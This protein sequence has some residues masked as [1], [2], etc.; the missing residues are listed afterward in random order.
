MS[1]RAKA[2]LLMVLSA[3]S[4]AAMQIVIAKSAA[5][6]P[7]F[8]QLFFRNLFAAGGA[9]ISVRRQG[10]RLM[11][12]PENRKLLVLRSAMGYLGMICL[13]YASAHAAQGDVAVMNKMSPFIVTLLAVVFLREKVARYQVAALALAF[14]GAAVVSNPTF[15][16]ELF[17]IFVA[18]LSAL[19]SGMAYTAVGALKGREAPGVVVFFFSA[20]ST[21]LSMVIMIPDFV[22]PTL[23]Q[24][25]QLVLIGLF[26]LGGQVTLTLSYAMARASE[27]SI[28]N[29]SGILFSMLFSALFLSQPV[30]ASSA[31][32]AVLV[33]LAGIVTLIGQKRAEA[34]GAGGDNI[35]KLHKT[36]YKKL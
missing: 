1:K 27:V 12:K 16:S 10:H 33:I 21:L 34:R 8:E 6:I 13:F 35:A 26:A 30:K 24:L 23:V 22:V 7:L 17:P 29:Y 32:G 5:G 20:C 18:L 3:M 14:A 4:F 15:Q 11:G 2:S 19:F 28:F 36:I 25:L 9:Y 31:F